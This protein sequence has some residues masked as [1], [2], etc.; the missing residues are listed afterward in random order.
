MPAALFAAA[1]LLIFEGLGWGS[2]FWGENRSRLHAIIVLVPLA[3]MM[4]LS[5][6]RMPAV[7]SAA[8][9]GRLAWPALVA[10]V[11][12]L[13]ALMAVGVVRQ[14]P[15]SGDEYAYL[16]QAETFAAGRL[17]NAPPALGRS[18]AAT[19]LWVAN[20]KWVGQYPPG[21][22]A[23][24][25]PFVRAGVPWLANVLLALLAVAGLAR[26][27][28]DA[29]GRD[30]SWRSA[31]L[32]GLSPFTIF[33]AASLFA[34]QLAATAT[35]GALLCSR[36]ARERRTML[37][38][39]L[40]GAACGL[41]GITRLPA[42]VPCAVVLAC[43]LLKGEDKPRRLAGLL[44]GAAPFAVLLL[45]Y[46]YAV[47]GSPFRPAY[48]IGGREV[49]H[50]YFDGASLAEA[51]RLTAFRFVELSLWASPLIVPMWAWAFWRKARSGTW[52]AAD[53][54]FPAG[55]LLFLLYPLHPGF[56]FGPRYFFDF[57]PGLVF[58]IATVT[59]AEPGRLDRARA[60]IR[61]SVLY[62]VLVMVA[63][64]ADYRSVIDDRLALFRAVDRIGPSHAVVCVHGGSG[65]LLPMKESDLVRNGISA[66][67]P[68]L[69][70]RCSMID[71]ASLARIYPDRDIWVWQTGPDG[72]QALSPYRTRGA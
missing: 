17:W 6:P 15:N 28:S 31:L 57:F 44:L 72:R 50:L 49:D 58:T 23:L 40:A 7:G 1:I 55:V 29:A 43:D 60:L 36:R 32:F 37:P 18:A 27:A 53:L 48:W 24:L 11:A 12:G 54:L 64:A 35:I 42:A 25:A 16:F 5:V 61:V 34:H 19:F 13:I 20:G 41:A 8:R 63:L 46:Q 3:T 4:F 45:G 56:R 9:A 65:R 62:G 47:T 66:D 69:Y 51:A 59:A 10:G 39:V 38:A 68:V 22:P 70:A 2:I 30:A 67:E 21:W 71:P 33:T 14:F 52:E 26:L